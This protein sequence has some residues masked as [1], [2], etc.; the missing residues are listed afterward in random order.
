VVNE[1]LVRRS[2]AGQD[3]IGRRLGCGLDSPKFMTIVGVVADTRAAD[4]SQPPHPAIYMPHWQHPNYGRAMSFVVRTQG[5]PMAMAEA[6]RRKVREVNSEI[7]VKFTTMDERLAQT[8]ASPRF[9]GILL[10]VFAGLAVLL[11]MAGVYGMMAYMVGQRTAEIGLRMALGAG[12]A[13]I[14]RMVLKTGAGVAAW[15]LALG[16]AGALA[17]TRLVESMLFGVKATDPSTFAIMAAAVG[18]VA[19][20][21]CFFP[22][23]RAARIDPLEALRQE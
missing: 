7:P 17:A 3:P 20:A 11:A 4:P 13:S 1:A 5:E 9:R 22:A 16:F 10:G 21:A 12:R 8:V 19:I 23:W 6:I 2:F 15:G 18:L 14:V